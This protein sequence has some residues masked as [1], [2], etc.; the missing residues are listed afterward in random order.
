MLL[1]IGPTP[2]QIRAALL[3]RAGEAL[4]GKIGLPAPMSVGTAVQALGYQPP[5][6][7]EDVRA[8][9]DVFVVQMIAT[10]DPR[11]LRRIH[12]QFSAQEG[13]NQ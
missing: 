3:T 4:M 2:D 11:E 13:L 1:K 10:A 5:A 6:I 12:H 7:P 9:W 8:R